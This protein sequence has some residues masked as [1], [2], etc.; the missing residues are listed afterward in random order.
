MTHN[1]EDAVE[2]KHPLL[3]VWNRHPGFLQSKT[4]MYR[5][6]SIEKIIAELFSVGAYYYYT[7]QLRSSTLSNHHPDILKMH[8]FTEF[9]RHL[10][11]IIDLIHPDDL[12][13]VQ[14]A[15]LMTLEKM[16]EIGFEHMMQLKAAYCFR[17]RVESGG[18]EM[19]YHQ[20][21]PTLKSE[22]GE[23]L[24]A[25]NIHTNIHH[26]TPRN[27]YHVVVSGIGERRNFHKM[28]WNGRKTVR[29]DALI[30]SKREVEIIALLA[31]GLKTGAI[32][33][34]LHISNHTVK[35]HRRNMLQKT[36]CKN[37]SELISLAFLQGYL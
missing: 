22:S 12:T 2:K 18:Y 1:N 21:L 3:T 17:M 27:N 35:T 9:P 6:P 16:S 29:P 8:S 5:L 26:I 33:E 11:D 4:E 37:S 28:Q 7:L 15:E 31:K 34:K 13:F 10:G 23:L 24:E 32:S 20:S 19:F 14:E 30:L 25:V 36:Q